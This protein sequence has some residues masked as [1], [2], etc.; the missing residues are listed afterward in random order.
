LLYYLSFHLWS[1]LLVASLRPALIPLGCP[2][3]ICWVVNINNEYF[4][5]LINHKWRL[6]SKLL[7]TEEKLEKHIS[8]HLLTLDIAS[9]QLLCPKI[10]EKNTEY[11]QFQLEKM[12]KLLLLEVPT[13]DTK[14]KLS[15]SKELNIQFKS[16]NLPR[17]KLMELLIKSQFTHQ[18]S[19]LSNWKKLKID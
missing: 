18:M 11:D 6:T 19:L 1:L 13:K 8:L 7:I 12:I 4:I 10:W 2:D 17:I 9:C 16:T 5:K 3:P 15:K 14:E